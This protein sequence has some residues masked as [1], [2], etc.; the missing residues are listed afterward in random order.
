MC[1]KQAGR[2]STASRNCHDPSFARGVGIPDATSPA[3]GSKEDSPERPWKLDL[4]PQ[5]TDCVQRNG[6]GG[7]SYALGQSTGQPHREYWQPD[8]FVRD[9]GTSY[10]DGL[11]RRLTGSSFQR[12]TRREMA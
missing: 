3:R 11:G 9:S 12:H 1:G 8:Q 6:G 2:T 10:D 7:E 5:S 4:G